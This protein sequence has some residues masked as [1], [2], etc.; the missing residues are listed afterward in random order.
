MMV[1]SI[2]IFAIIF[3]QDLL[4]I[5]LDQVNTFAKFSILFFLMIFYQD[6]FIYT[7]SFSIKDNIIFQSSIYSN[8]GRCMDRK[9][10][11]GKII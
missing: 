2:H 9:V 3:L 6:L 5:G 4:N 8:F 10:Y 1:R 7:L 11:L